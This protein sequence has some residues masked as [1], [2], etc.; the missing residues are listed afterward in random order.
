LSDDDDDDDDDDTPA[1]GEPLPAGEHPEPEPELPG[2][3]AAKSDAPIIGGIAAPP[4][5][6]ETEPLRGRLAAG[7]AAEPGGD[8]DGSG[9][10]RGTFGE[11]GFGDWRGDWPPGDWLPVECAPG[12]CTL[13]PLAAAA[14]GDRGWQSTS[15]LI[16]PDRPL[17]APNPGESGRRAA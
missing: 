17:A 8:G 4:L 10:C 2:G 16:G 5:P 9:D 15:T 11:S 1:A 12:E 3:G 6:D 14:P 13:L 7:D